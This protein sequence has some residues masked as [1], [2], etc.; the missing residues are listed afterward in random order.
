[1]IKESNKFN[2][3][4]SKLIYPLF[5][6]EKEGPADEVKSMSGVFKYSLEALKD[7]LVNLDHLGIRNI[8][9]FGLPVQKSWRGKS[10][11]ESNYFLCEAI[12]F[13][14]SRYPSFTIFTDICLC[15]Y[16][17]HGHCGIV[18]EGQVAID[19]T[20]T[21][22]ALAAMALLHAKAGAD[23][24]CPSAMAE[25]QVRAIRNKLDQNGYNQVKIMAYSAKFASQFYGPFR[26]I[27]DSAPRFGDRRAYQ[28]D[29]H[30]R[31]TALEKIRQD[32][33]EGAGIVMVKPALAYLDIIVQA[34]RQFNFPLAVYNVSG[35]Y[36]LAKLGAQQG[37]WSEEDFVFELIGAI[38]RAGADYIISYH[39]AD[40][41][42]WQKKY[43]QERILL[44]EQSVV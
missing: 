42:Y 39:A 2:L 3:S 8:L 29:Y 4:L 21:L 32:I 5:V 24:V 22:K 30:D 43:E 6:K 36:A 44:R 37:F 11:W 15:A 33:K 38:Q 20:L 35:E 23:F 41:A 31:E 13:I 19:N 9:L 28:L 40:I 14:K 16:S 1:M 7:E 25:N 18:L 10:A 27:A 26:E 34:K 17:S 12:S